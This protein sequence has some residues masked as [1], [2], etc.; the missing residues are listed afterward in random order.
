MADDLEQKLIGIFIAIFAA[1]LLIFI[2]TVG[3]M[4]I[5][6]AVFYGNPLVGALPVGSNLNILFVTIVSLPFSLGTALIYVYLTEWRKRG[7]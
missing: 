5:F 2:G 6:R 4:M 1:F 3:L 7:K